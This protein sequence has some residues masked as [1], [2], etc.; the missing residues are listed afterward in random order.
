MEERDILALW[1]S[2]DQ[3]LEANL[4][5]NRKNTADITGMKVQ[6][7]LA[8]M[9]PIKIFTLVVGVLWVLFVDTLIINLFAIANPFFLISAGIQVLLTKFAI[10]IYLYQLILIHQVDVSEPIV[11]TQ[12]RLTRLQSSTLWVARLLFLQLP[13]WTTFY[14]NKSMLENGN[15]FLYII[16]IAVTL[17]FA[18]LAVWLFLNIRYENRDKKWFKLIFDGIEWTPVI[19]S[20]ELYRGIEAF[21]EDVRSL[22]WKE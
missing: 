18:F 17:A 16:Q 9:K 8:S 5:L 19:R 12:S 3:K 21:N 1:K 6:S 15:T 11:A 20:M 13:V 10:G 2:Y 4:L 22:N 14:W 7:L